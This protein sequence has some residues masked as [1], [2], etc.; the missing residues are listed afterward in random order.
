MKCSR[1]GSTQ[2]EVSIW[3]SMFKDLH[4]DVVCCWPEGLE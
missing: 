1:C 3:H 2:R 4:D